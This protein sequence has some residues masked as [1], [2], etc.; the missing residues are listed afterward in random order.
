[1][2]D[3]IIDNLYVNKELL[4]ALLEP[5]CTKYKLTMTELKVLLFLANNKQYNTATEIVEG[6]KIAKSHIS[7]SVRDLTER[8]YLQGGY[9]GNNHR[10]IRLQLCEQSHEIIR[11]GRRVQKDFLSIVTNGFD[12]NEIKTFKSFVSRM[13]ENANGYLHGQMNGK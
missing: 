9:E 8:G 1:M 13:T 12:E 7:S 4:S 10:T 3:S 11:E 6:L 5:V 2:M